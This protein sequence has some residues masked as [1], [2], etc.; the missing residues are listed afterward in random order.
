MIH[1]GV[2]SLKFPCLAM[3]PIPQPRPA[4][5][6]AHTMVPAGEQQH[7]NEA[8]HSEATKMRW[9]R[10]AVMGVH[11]AYGAGIGK[12]QETAIVK[13]AMQAPRPTGVPAPLQWTSEGTGERAMKAHYPGVIR[14]GFQSGMRY[15]PRDSKG[16]NQACAYRPYVSW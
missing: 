15:M 14:H 4:V 9:Q 10:R 13:P 7:T 3:P 1:A 8:V 2:L 6:A 11:L 12:V 5:P 16:L